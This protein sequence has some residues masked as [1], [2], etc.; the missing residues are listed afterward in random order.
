MKCVARIRKS[1]LQTT[2]FSLLARASSDSSW[3]SDRTVQEL[4]RPLTLKYGNII[5]TGLNPSIGT[6]N[7]VFLSPLEVYS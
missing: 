4:L 2:K 6:D 3:K 7:F 1:R 5:V